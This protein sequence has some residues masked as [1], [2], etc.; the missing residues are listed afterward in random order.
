MINREAAGHLLKVHDAFAHPITP[1]MAGAI[2]V[3]LM[4]SIP[5][6][7]ALHRAGKMSDKT[8]QDVKVRC[9][10]WCVIAP[11]VVLPILLSA[12]AAMLMVCAVSLMCHREFARATGLFRER[13]MSAMVVLGIL[14]VTFASLDNWYGLFVAVPALM[15]AIIPAAAVLEDRPKHYIQRV[16]LAAVAFLFFGAGLG[17]LGFIANDTDYRPVLLLIIVC[18]QLNDIFAYI[19]GKTLG[20]RKLFPNNSPNKTLGGHLGAVCCTVPLTFFLGREVFRGTPMNDPVLL[21]GLGLIFSIGGQLGDLVLGSIKRDIGIK[22]M[23][24]T[25]PGHG[26]VLDR[27]NSLLLVAPAAGHYLG[28]FGGLDYDRVDRVLSTGLRALDSQIP[29]LVQLMQRAGAWVI[30]CAAFVG[31]GA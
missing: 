12:G 24:A 19:C 4:V 13:L 31:G 10:T 7:L 5:A 1:W 27:A 11:A 17:H 29:M 8:W 21:V 14:A 20:R 16:A 30:G 26:G 22:D 18:V 2:G 15:M 23:A 9:I 28:Y 25:L 3:V 6:A